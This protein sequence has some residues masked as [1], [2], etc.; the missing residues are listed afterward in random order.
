V[1]VVALHLLELAEPET[2]MVAMVVVEWFRTLVDRLLPTLLEAEVALET[3]DP[4]ASVLLVLVVMEEDG[5]AMVF[6]HLL[7]VV[8]EEAVLEVPNRQALHLAEEPVVLVW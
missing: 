4:M 3:A 2:L 8:V 5:K 6:Q 7:I 1:E